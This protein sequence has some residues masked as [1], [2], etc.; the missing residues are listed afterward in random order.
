MCVGD[1]GYENIVLQVG[2]ATEDEGCFAAWD[3][4]VECGDR[5]GVVGSEDGGGA[6]GA[7]TEGGGV[8]GEDEILREGLE[9]GARMRLNIQRKGR[10]KEG[11]SVKCDR[12]S[13]WIENLGLG[14]RACFAYIPLTARI[15]SS[16]ALYSTFRRHL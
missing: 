4:T 12:A 8:C 11:E 3:A 1:V 14:L 16:H 2:A 9:Y 10:D 13:G 15:A 6:E 7:G 5:Y